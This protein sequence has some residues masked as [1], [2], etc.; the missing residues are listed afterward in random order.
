MRERESGLGDEACKRQFIIY[1]QQFPERS[2]SGVR[3]GRQKLQNSKRY[4]KRLGIA[5]VISRF[6]ILYILDREAYTILM[7]SVLT[8]SDELSGLRSSPIFARLVSNREGESPTR[9]SWKGFI[10]FSHVSYVSYNA[11]AGRT[12]CMNFSLRR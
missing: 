8:R 9:A 6:R 1:K 2:R 7:R 11:R 5:L 4:S 12:R 3:K 10:A